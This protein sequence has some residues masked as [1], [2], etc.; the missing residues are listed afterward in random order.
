MAGVE[1]WWRTIDTWI[2]CY[3]PYAK[4]R[5]I[6]QWVEKCDECGELRR[7]TEERYWPPVTK[8]LHFS[9]NRA[10]SHESSAKTNR[11]DA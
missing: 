4:R 1:P 9:G 10:I 6:H 8:T 5:L 3:H 7:A 2:N 11:R